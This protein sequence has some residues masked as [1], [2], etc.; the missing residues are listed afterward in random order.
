MYRLPDDEN[1]SFLRGLKAE[2]VCFAA[3]QVNLHFQGDVSITIFGSFRHIA[4]EG[5]I[6]EMDG[7]FPLQSSEL[8]RLLE[9]EINSVQTKADATLILG[10]SN[11]DQL[12]I[13]GDNGPY[14]SYH[15]KNGEKVVIV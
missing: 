6:P 2:L 10:F 12:V 11:G 3:Y 8:M 13:E 9:E 4:S 1:L 14:E 5:S 15:V 7:S